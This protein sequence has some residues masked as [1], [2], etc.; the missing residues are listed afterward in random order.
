MIALNRSPEPTE[1]NMEG[2]IGYMYSQ[3]TQLRKKCH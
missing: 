3:D 1:Y 2:R